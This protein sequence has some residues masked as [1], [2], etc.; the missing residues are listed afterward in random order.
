MSNPTTHVSDFDGSAPGWT[1]AGPERYSN[2]L[3][4]EEAG[5]NLVRRPSGEGG[6][7]ADGAVSA[8]ATVTNVT[9]ESYSGTHAVRVQFPGDGVSRIVEWYTDNGGGSGAQNFTA[10]YWVKGTGQ[11]RI[12]AGQWVNGGGALRQQIGSLVTLTS[13]WQFLPAAFSTNPGDTFDGAGTL[14]VESVTPVSPIDCYIDAL[15]QEMKAYRTSYI[16]GGQG[17]GYAWDGTAHVT[18]STRAA[19]SAAISPTG[20]LSPVEGA[21]AFRLTPTIETGVE[22]IWGECGVK[23][24]GTDH[25]R[26]GRNSTKHPF[27][28]WSSN[29]AAYERLTAAQTVDAGIQFFF[30]I[31]HSGATQYLQVDE[32]LPLSTS[33]ASVSGSWGAGN[34]K[35]EAT[36]GGVVYDELLAA[37]RM[38]VADEILTLLDTEEWYFSLLY[39]PGPPPPPFGILTAHIRTA[40]VLSAGLIEATPLTAGRSR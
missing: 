22:E 24:L 40:P 13:D 19:S 5:I 29:D 34:L 7:I 2:G 20:I 1:I 31:G 9:S 11:V 25:L 4:L 28:E 27:V 10:G 18:R 30:L 16:D 21:L 12:R 26:W 8:G 6:A 37:N 14:R 32:N 17:S 15:Q 3:W 35:L 36:A 38:L 23:G 33:R 39:D